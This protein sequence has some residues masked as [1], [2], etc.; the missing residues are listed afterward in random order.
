MLTLLKVIGPSGNLVGASRVIFASRSFS[1]I[2]KLKPLQYSRCLKDSLNVTSKRTVKT[3][4]VDWKPIISTKG[5][6]TTLEHQAKMPYLRKFFLGLMIAMPLVSFILGCWQVKRLQWKTDLISRCENALAQPPIEEIPA[7]LDP[8]VIGEFEYRRF[9]CKGHFDY[10]QE[11]FLGPRIRDG[12]LGYLVITPF[13]RASGGKPILI[14]R[15]WIHKDKVV[16]ETRKH[17]YLSHLAFPQGEIEIEALFRVMPVKS[18]LQF[19]HEDGSRLFNVH[20]IPVMAKQSGSLPIYCQMIYDLSDHVEW[21]LPEDDTAKGGKKNSSSWKNFIFAS[22]KGKEEE[23]DAHFISHQRESE[24]DSTLE[25]QDFE[26]VKEG[27]PIAATP[28]LKFSN[29]HLQYLVTWFGLSIC[30]AGL[31]IYIFLKKGR[32]SSAE[33]VI[34]EKRRNMKKE[35][36]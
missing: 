7:D 2:P 9:K 18:V 4:T 14:E 16:P 27:V 12:Q 26:F 8:S 33:K 15:G 10:S 24:H 22:N 32:F 21:R 34:A 28:K 31:L 19:D 6:L 29:N 3:S 5:N 36:L 17:G 11:M 35:F 20:D 25:F 23:D 30:S 1:V 13:V